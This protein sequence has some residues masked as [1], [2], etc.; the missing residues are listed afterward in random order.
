M[1]FLITGDWHL[2]TY[3]PRNRT[4]NYF[5]SQF[6]KVKWI[7]ELAQAEGCDFILQPGDMFNSHKASDFLKQHYINY[8]I[9]EKEYLATELCTIFGQHDLRF[10]SSDKKNTPLAVLNSAGALRLIA[11]D[12][13]YACEY[14][15]QRIFIYG[16]NWGEEIPPVD[17]REGVHVLLIHKL[18]VEDIEGWERHYISTENMFRFS[19]HDIIVCGD[20][21]LSFMAEKFDEIGQTRLLFNCGSLMRSRIDQAKHEPKVYIVD[22]CDLQYEEHKI[23]VKPIEEVMNVEKAEQEKERNEQLE[24]FVSKLTG[25]VNIEGL[26]FLRNLETYI[27]ENEVE[28]PVK[29]FI[30][31]VVAGEE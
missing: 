31:E 12:E 8:L 30:N 3:S 17:D 5:E 22:I 10:H 11:N 24:A 7:F 9:V 13:P 2:D 21:H 29:D 27:A 15:K 26:D 6:E 28:S 20:N 16:C 14:D 23:P 4:D 25:D 1:K 19:D 18:V